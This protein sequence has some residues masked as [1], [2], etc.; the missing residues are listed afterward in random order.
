M[1]YNYE[2]I[3]LIYLSTKPSTKVN[4]MT[5]LLNRSKSPF[6]RSACQDRS[7]RTRQR[8]I[9]V[10]VEVFSE[11]GY[12]AASTRT[13]VERAQANLVSIPYYFGSKQGLYHASA[14]YIGAEVTGRFRPA[15]D[16][17]RQGLAQAGLSRHQTLELF[18]E[19]MVDF[20]H[21]ML[22]TDAPDC[23]GQFI[24]REQSQ[25][26]EAF[27]I[28]HAHFSN[29]VDIGIE[30]VSRLT[31][32]AVEAPATRLQFMT[33]ISMVLFTRTNR[34]SLLRTMEWKSIGEDERHLVEEILRQNMHALY[35][36]SA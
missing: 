9:E 22:G 30:F 7:E 18:T 23:W 26:T 36:H 16:R 12:E 2:I 24:L 31:G 33:T 25:P 1:Y 20:A 14:E 28:L 15:C 17:A 19:F 4:E 8:L 5:K 29:I 32:R 34:A 27:D 11:L 10:A 35:A 6:G 21:V 13:I 3:R